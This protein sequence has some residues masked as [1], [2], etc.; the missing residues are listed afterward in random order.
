MTDFSDRLMGNL[1]DK[2]L[3]AV[4]REATLA[5]ML[6][7]TMEGDPPDNVYETLQKYGFVD[8]NH[9]WLYD[10]EDE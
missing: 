4:E 7:R 8:E 3:E 2:A 6:Y 10:E 5:Y 9:E 1:L